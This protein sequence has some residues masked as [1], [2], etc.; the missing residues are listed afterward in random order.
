MGGKLPKS[1]YEINGKTVIERQIEQIRRMYE[2]PEIIVVAGFHHASM[3][4]HL[5]P[6]RE[7]LSIVINEDWE[8]TG[9]AASV[10]IAARVSSNTRLVSI[11]GDTLITDE[12]LHEVVESGRDAIGVTRISSETPVFVEVSPEMQCISFQRTNPN[13]LC[14]WEY[15]G[16][17][18]VSK[19]GA[20][21][22]G[23]GHVFQG[24]SKQLPVFAIPIDG[25]EFDTQEEFSRAKDWVA[26]GAN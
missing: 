20:L 9:T 1:L 2:N 26:R 3:I 16:P 6:L 19:S 10:R 14:E 25:I 12:S 11:D 13:N 24:L 15:M 23:S 8:T 17:T 5:R 4:E 7:N 21:K 22:L 18:S